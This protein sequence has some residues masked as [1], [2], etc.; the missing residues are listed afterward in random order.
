MKKATPSTDGKSMVN[1]Q[2]EFISLKEKD[3][4]I[5]KT[6]RISPRSFFIVVGVTGF[7]PATPR[8]PDAYSNRAELHPENGCKSSTL[9]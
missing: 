1:C 7:E 3:T 8:P 2:R 6:A 9:F 5:K 4:E